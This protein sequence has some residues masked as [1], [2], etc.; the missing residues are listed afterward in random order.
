[1]LQRCFEALRPARP[2]VHCIT[3]SVTINDC[4]NVLLAAGARPIMADAPEE[5]AEITAACQALV[6]NLGMLSPRKLEA[7]VK[8]GHQ[9]NRMGI[10]V[11]LDPVGAGA[12]ALRTRA[13]HTLLEEVRFAAV[14]GNGSE[15]RVLAAGG[16][17]HG[18]VDAAPG[19]CAPEQ[20][21]AMAE[22]L[23][24]R[25]HAVVAVTGETDLVTDGTRTARCLGGCAEMGLV[26]GTGCMLSAL[27]GALLAVSPEQP[28]AAVCTAV[29]AMKTA[30]ELARAAL[31]PDEGSGSYRV[32]LI[33]AVNRLDGPTLA[34][35]AQW[36]EL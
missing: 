19:E 33:D 36:E 15:I 20:E 6:L 24:R 13:V 30:G 12:S 34:A 23:A 27:T 17:N 29:C 9:A 3:N 5:S 11:V 25:I 26:T 22:A 4:A 28:F 35:R 7:M 18:G 21:R 1:M 10:P 2:M 31:A 8:S 16:E 14:R 32:R